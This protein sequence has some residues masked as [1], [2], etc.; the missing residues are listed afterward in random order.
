MI[1]DH[2]KYKCCLTINI[3]SS[4]NYGENFLDYLE[5]FFEERLFDYLENLNVKFSAALVR[6]TLFFL[7]LTVSGSLHKRIFFFREIFH[8]KNFTFL[9]TVQY[10]I[11]FRNDDMVLT[12]WVIIYLYFLISVA[13]FH[14][15]FEY[16][17]ISISIIVIKMRTDILMFR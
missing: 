8:I 17:I 7:V 9:H 15:S 14:F 13:R 2:V 4:V 6:M 16:F 5:L 11:F 10:I 3:I 12:N 1:N